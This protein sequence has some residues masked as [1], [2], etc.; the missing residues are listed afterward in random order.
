MRR[1]FFSFPSILNDSFERQ[2]N[3]GGMARVYI[4]PKIVMFFRG[5]LK[6]STRMMIFIPEN[7][8]KGY[9]ISA[10]IIVFLRLKMRQVFKG[11]NYCF[12]LDFYLWNHAYITSSNYFP[13]CTLPIHLI[14]INTIL[15]VSKSG[16]FLDSTAQ[17]FC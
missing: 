2:V 17:S 9:C 6:E 7:K 14:S 12:F 4:L 1:D 13:F 15:I 3:G 10:N 5:F 11:G 16:H 8:E